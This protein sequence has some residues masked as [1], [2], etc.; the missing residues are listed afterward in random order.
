MPIGGSNIRD[1][2]RV[3]KMDVICNL[4]DARCARH[5]G[6]QRLAIVTS[7]CMATYQATH[8]FLDPR[9][10]VQVARDVVQTIRGSSNNNNQDNNARFLAR[11]KRNTFRDIGDRLA[12]RFV[13]LIIRRA[14][15]RALHADEEQR[16]TTTSIITASA[17]EQQEQADGQEAGEEETVTN[18][19]GMVDEGTDMEPD[20]S[21][22]N[23]AVSP[24]DQP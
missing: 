10:R 14:A 21:S 3:Q 8:D 2:S 13:S 17:P 15:E 12:L 1:M 22:R 20:L 23:L 6:N 16:P 4:R 7:R 24:A 18:K 9:D 5:P 11:T 19:E